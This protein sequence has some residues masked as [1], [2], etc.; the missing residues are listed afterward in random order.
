M[1]TPAE[2]TLIDRAAALLADLELDSRT[3]LNVGAGGSTVVEDEILQRLRGG[4][5]CDRVDVEP[6]AVEHPF[7][8]HSI[9][10]S[11]E[12]MTRVGSDQYTLVMSNY[13]FEHVP[14]CDAALREVARVL[15][16]GGRFVLTVPNPTAPE[17]AVARRTPTWFHEA[18]RGRPEGGSRAYPT[19]YAY[20]SIDGL[21]RAGQAAGL[22]L[23]GLVQTSFLFGYLVRW[24]PLAPLARAWDGGVNRLA[25]RSMQG[26]AC[27]TLRKAGQSA[28]DRM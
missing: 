11:V 14:D 18:L 15:R 27:L 4:F 16:P 19:F 8:R 6:C 28:G 23:E 9:V 12:R 1:Q 10:E 2:A 7:V 13:V 25:W 21:V 5:V 24:R 3:V 22:W 26:H 17:F 20:G